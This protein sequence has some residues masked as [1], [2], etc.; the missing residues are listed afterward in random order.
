MLDTYLIPNEIIYG[1][2]PMAIPNIAMSLLMTYM[3]LRLAYSYV[4]WYG[5]DSTALYIELHSHVDLRP[6]LPS[7]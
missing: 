1:Y 2:M 7:P 6:L 4:Q 5:S 3:Q